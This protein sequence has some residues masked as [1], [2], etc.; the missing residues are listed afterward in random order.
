[1]DAA[2]PNGGDGAPSNIN[3]AFIVVS[4]FS[5]V[6]I[7]LPIGPHLKARNIG[8][9]AFVGWCFTANLIYFINAI[10]WYHS[11]RNAPGWADFSM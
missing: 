6:L 10:V 3:I 1:M 9:L 2:L 8:T 4:F 11:I 5:M 7:L